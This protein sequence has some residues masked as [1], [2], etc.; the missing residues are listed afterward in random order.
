MHKLNKFLFIILCTSY[1]DSISWQCVWISL[2]IFVPWQSS[3]YLNTLS[4]IAIAI[5]IYHC[6][7][8]SML[9]KEGLSK[10]RMAWLMFGQLGIYSTDTSNLRSVCNNIACLRTGKGSRVS[11][12]GVQRNL[13]SA[14]LIWSALTAHTQHFTAHFLPTVW[15]CSLKH[16][17]GCFLLHVERW[18]TGL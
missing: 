18:I 1:I 12:P 13:K 2:Y 5:L 4:C 8:F 11:Q 15:G 14:H 7:S 9:G 16:G 6:E 3:I 10:E 17:N